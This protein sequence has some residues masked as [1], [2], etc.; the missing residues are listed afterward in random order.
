MDLSSTAQ[1]PLIEQEQLDSLIDVAG[2]E[3]VRSILEAF[4]RSTDDLSADL[5]RCLSGGECANVARSAHA[6]KGSAANVGA[7]RLSTAARAVEVHAK[8]GDLVAAKGAID[9]LMVVYRETRAA[10]EKHVS[11]RG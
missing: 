8:N 11:A 5:E 4:W 6:I 7:N 9:R 3:G 10:L 2:V 1:A